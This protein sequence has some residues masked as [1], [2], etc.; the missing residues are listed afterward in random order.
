MSRPAQRTDW[1][2]EEKRRGSPTS[3]RIA[4]AT[5]GADPVVGHQRAAATQPPRVTLELEVQQPQLSVEVLDHRQGDL[6]LLLIGRRQGEAGQLFAGVVAFEAAEPAGLRRHAM[7]EQ[8]GVDA[9][10]PLGALIEERLAQPDA[11]R[12][13]RMCAGGIQASG[14]RRSTSSSRNSRG[15]GGRS[16][17]AAW[18]ALGARVG[19]LGRCASA[20]TPSTTN[21]QPVIASTPATSCRPS[22]RSRSNGEVHHF[23]SWNPGICRSA[24]P[25]DRSR[26]SRLVLAS[27]AATWAARPVPLHVRP[28]CWVRY[29]AISTR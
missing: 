6:N 20:P 21:R 26:P 4:V 27:A 19:R 5:L 2:E 9:L 11:A 16:W 22:K 13:S 24:P 18:P 23:T 12:R 3:A 25:P 15:R 14:N 7:M 29:G 17:R 10:Q 8:H 1:R 28:T